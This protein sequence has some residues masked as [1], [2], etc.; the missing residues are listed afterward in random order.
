MPVLELGRVRQE[1]VSPRREGARGRGHW[2]AL[3]RL[4]AWGPCTRSH[5]DGPQGRDAADRAVVTGA[6]SP[7]RR[8]GRS[9]RA[10]AGFVVRSVFPAGIDP[11]DRG[12]APGPSVRRLRLCVPWSPLCSRWAA[13]QTALLLIW[14][15]FTL[16]RKLLECF[17]ALLSRSSG[18]RL[19]LRGK[20]VPEWRPESEPRAA[21]PGPSHGT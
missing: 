1:G 6:V 2:A 21:F 12:M 14:S 15:N 11:S 7:S 3:P 10:S 17:K 16:I 13:S 20:L 8:R 5:R 19:G 18:G 9:V 4:L